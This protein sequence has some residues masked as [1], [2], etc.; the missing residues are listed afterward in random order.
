MKT[1]TYEEQQLMAIFNSAGTRQGLISALEE[2][3]GQLT[4]EDAELKELTDSSLDKLRD[5]T[6]A[7]FDTLDLFPDFSEEDEDAG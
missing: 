6:D 7:E 2:M 1:I 4:A 3:H 5:M